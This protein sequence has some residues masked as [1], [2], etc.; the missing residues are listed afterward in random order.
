MS[1]QCSACWARS[2]PTSAII[3]STKYQHHGRRPVAVSLSADALSGLP[4][5]AVNTV[6]VCDQKPNSQRLRTVT[7]G[8][9]LA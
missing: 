4:L 7:A 9:H 3:T 1:L 2:S 5:D 6:W 8:G